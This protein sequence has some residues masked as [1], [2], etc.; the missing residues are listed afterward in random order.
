[1]PLEHTILQSLPTAT[2]NVPS[3]QKAFTVPSIV[4]GMLSPFTGSL[5]LSATGAVGIKGGA[6][7]DIGMTFKDGLSSGT[8]EAEATLGV[9]ATGEVT[10]G[11]STFVNPQGLANDTEFV[12][13]KRSHSG[14]APA[15]RGANHDR[16]GRSLQLHDGRGCAAGD[17]SGVTETITVDGAQITLNQHDKTVSIVGLSAQAVAYGQTSLA[18]TASASLQRASGC[19][20]RPPLHP[21]VRGCAN[22]RC[23]V[24]MLPRL[25]WVVQVNSDNSIAMTTGLGVCP[26]LPAHCCHPTPTQPTHPLAKLG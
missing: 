11:G 17:A 26:E 16:F 9:S 22:Q 24:A 2:A 4:A 20:A 15:W 1:M 21:G 5:S 10:V 23:A 14:L 6:T 13:H 25:H 12:F 19:P 8:I 18:A 3:W 7:A